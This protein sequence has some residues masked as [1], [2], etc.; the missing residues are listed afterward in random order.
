MKQ[1]T[2]GWINGFIGVAIFSGTLPATRVAVQQL[3]PLFVTS[4]RACIAAVLGGLLLCLLKQTRP[5]AAQLRSLILVSMGVVLGFPLFT[6]L[7]LQHASSAH[8]IVFVGLLPLSTALFA[9]WRGGER[10]KPLFWA[11]ALVGAISVASYALLNSDGAP[12]YSDVLMLAAIVVCGMGYAEGAKLSREL[13]GWQV[14]SWAL[15]LSLPVILPLALWSW[16]SPIAPVHSNAWWSLAY[17]SV[18]SMLIGFVFWYQGLAQG[19]TAAVGQL[20]LLQPFMGLG[21]AALLLQEHIH[22]SMLVVTVVAVL[23]VAGAK[24]FAH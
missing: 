1:H 22:P 19:G 6:S 13:G 14:I 8:M 20:Q 2:L 5:H 18:F 16:P 4:A 17:V 7:A 24:R 21:L 10:P 23:C 11:F 12:W 9:V 3:P 15:L